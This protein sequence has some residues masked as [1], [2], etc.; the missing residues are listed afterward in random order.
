MVAQ[1][2][3][4]EDAVAGPVAADLNHLKIEGEG[5]V[6]LSVVGAFL[7]GKQEALPGQPGIRAGVNGAVGLAPVQTGLKLPQ[8]CGTQPPADTAA[9]KT[10]P[11]G[12]LSL[13]V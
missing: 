6:I 2:F 1:G 4:P 8:I 12:E 13:F 9:D 11:A 5:V 7:L 10:V 3:F